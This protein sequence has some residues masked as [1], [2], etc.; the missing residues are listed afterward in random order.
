MSQ[1]STFYDVIILGAGAA[2]LMAAITASRR[3]RKVLILEKS[4]KVGKKILMS[5][6]GRCNFTNEFVEAENFISEN[7]HF[8]KSALNQF[9][10]SDFIN[11]VETHGIEYEKRKK[12]QYFCIHSSRQILD[13][14]LNECKSTNVEILCD[15]N[16]T[17]I[18]NNDST[19][20][21]FQI[22]CDQILKDSS[23]YLTFECESLLIATGALSI[24]TLGGSGYG[25]DV[26]TKYALEVTET[27]AGLVPFIF[28]DKY[29]TVFK[30]LAGISIYAEV[31]CNNQIFYDNILFTHKGISGPAILQISNYWNPGDVIKLNLVPDTNLYEELN[32]AKNNG[33]KIL[34]KT[35]LREFLPKSF[36]KEFENIW[37]EKY[38][39]TPLDKFNE[40]TL[41]SIANQ[42][43]NWTLNPSSTEGYRTA[44]VTVGGVKTSGISSKTMEVKDNPGL[45]FAGEVM[46]VTGHLGGYNFQWAWASGYCAGLNI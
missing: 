32:H 45:Y 14:L 31:E 37:W 10:P 16:V 30:N 5:G 38:K 13:M 4:N 18:H 40:P 43:H 15:I 1:T 26:A 36:L 11:L 12:N 3:G 24:P 19:I 42:I 20:K 46:D 28:T 2:G 34:L 8:C 44:E 41:K 21:K 22:N 7:E 23:N 27:R 35:F 25:Y 17:Q 33:E 39:K 6:G 29:Q 9:L